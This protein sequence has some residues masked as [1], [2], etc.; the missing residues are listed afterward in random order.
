MF[1]ENVKA[2]GVLTSQAPPPQVQFS[3]RVSATSFCKYDKALL[4]CKILQKKILK[5]PAL[6]GPL[7][8]EQ[9]EARAP[10][11]PGCA[12]DVIIF[13][14]GSKQLGLW[15]GGFR[16]PHVILKYSQPI[17]IWHT[18]FDF[19]SSRCKLPFDFFQEMQHGGRRG[20]NKQFS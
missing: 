18:T 14:A 5:M 10:V 7:T 1:A 17:L 20:Q 4:F 11:P 9:G 3:T 8:C 2:E 15:R 19:D 6:W 12:T 16:P 13:L